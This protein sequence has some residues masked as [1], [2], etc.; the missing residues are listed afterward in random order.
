LPEPEHFDTKNAGGRQLET[1]AKRRRLHRRVWS[2]F[3]P[4]DVTCQLTY[5]LRVTEFPVFHGDNIRRGRFR[6]GHTSSSM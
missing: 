4:Y 2:A 6:D 5:F 1:V 3:P